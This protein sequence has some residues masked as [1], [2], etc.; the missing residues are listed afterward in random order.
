MLSS[1]LRL[2]HQERLNKRHLI[3]E[4]QPETPRPRNRSLARD[5]KQFMQDI[6]DPAHFRIHHI[7][8]RRISLQT[9]KVSDIHPVLDGV[10]DRL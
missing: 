10:F 7:P 1:T 6:A 4:I 5:I 3:H 8:L 2:L 9:Q